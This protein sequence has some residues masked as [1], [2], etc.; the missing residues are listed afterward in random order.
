MSNEDPTTQ[1]ADLAERMLDAVSDADQ[2]WR[3]VEQCARELTEL[4][5]RTTR[6]TAGLKSSPVD[7]EHLRPGLENPPA[8]ARRESS[9]ARG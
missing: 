2:D 7:P 1:A 3:V 4:A 8:H 6:R 9:P 5:A